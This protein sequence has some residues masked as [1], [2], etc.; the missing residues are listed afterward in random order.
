MIVAGDPNG[1]P[2]DSPTN[3]VIPNSDI[4]SPFA[5]VG[6][7]QIQSGGSTFICTATPISARHVIS[8][9]HCLDLDANGSVD[10]PP[11]NVDFILNYGSDISHII[12]A[13]ALFVHPDWTGFA[14]P[15]VNDDVAVIELSTPLPDGVPIYGLNSDPFVS[16]ETLSMVG[17]GQSG[18]GVNGY[19]VGASFS[20][21]RGGGNDADSFELDDEGSGS[22]EVFYADFD[23]PTSSTNFLGGLTLGNDIETTLG[24]GDSGGPSFIDDG[25]GGI[26]IF[27]IN[28]FSFQ[29]TATLAPRFGS[30]AGGT[31]VSAYLDFIDPIIGP[32]D[33]GVTVAESG[34]LT[35]VIEGGA[36]DTYTFVL[37][38]APTANVAITS[39]SDTE[40]ST[41][42]AGVVFT[43]TNWNVAQ[44]VTV[45]AVDD[46]DVEGNHT[47]TITH[48][49]ASAD[50]AYNG[51]S[52]DGI[53]ANITD[54]DDPPI[55]PLAV[56]VGVANNV[57]DA[58]TTVS[59]NH[60]FSSMIVVAS[61]NYGGSDSPLVTRVR[62][63]SGNSFQV[64]VQRPNNGAVA[65]TGFD[66]HYLAVEAG[67]YTVASNGVKMEAVSFTS[68]VTDENNSWQGESKSYSNSYTN[69]VVIGQVMTQ[70]D[71]DWSVFWA[72]GN[73]RTAP[74]NSSNLT[75]GKHVA[76]DPTTARANETIGYVVLEA[77][78]G[79]I[80]STVNYVAALGADTIRGITDAPP[81]TYAL[82]GLSSVT[83]AVVSSAAMD[84][85]NGGWPLLYGTNP[86][87]PTALRLAIDEDQLRDPE[88]N[89][90][91]EQ[92]AY[93]VF[94][95]IGE[96]PSVTIQP[97]DGSTDVGEDGTTDTYTVVLEAQPTADVTINVSGDGQVAGA[98]VSL[99]FTALNWDTTQSVTVSAVDDDVAEGNH[100]GSIGHTATSADTA[101]DGIS[102]AGVQANI[103]DNDSAG[104]TISP[105]GGSTDVSEDGVT[106]GYTVVLTS[107]PTANVTITVGGDSQV[108][109][110]PTPLT[111]TPTNWGTAQTVTVSAADD[112]VDE[113]DHTGILTH[114]AVS[115]DGS[116]NGIS[117]S[118]VQ[119]NITDN[120]T[121]GVVITITGGSTDV[122]E[123]GATDNYSVVLSSQ[124][125]ANVTVTVN[126]DGQVTGTPTPLTFTAGNWDTVQ[127]VTVSAVDDGV[128]EGNH[129]GVL[130]HSATSSDGNYNGNSIA[131]V[132]ANITDNDSAG[133]VV[134]ESSGSTD[135]AEGGTSD[136]YTLVLTSQPTAT[137]TVTINSDS[138]VTGAPAPLTFTSANWDTAQTVTVT[139]V[140]DGVVEGNHAGTISHTAVSGDTD[141]NGISI[142]DVTANVTDNDSVGVEIVESGG[143]T[144]VAEGGASDTYA[145]VLTSQ[146]SGNVTITVG[147]DGQV[148]GSPGLLTFTSGNWNSAQTVAVTAVDD[149][150]VEGNHTGVLNHTAS[151]GDGSYDGISITDVTAN[152]TDNDSAGPNL[153]VGV[154]QNVNDAWTTVVLTST[155]SSMVVVASVNYD[156]SDAPMVTRVRNASG[157]SFEL[158][159]QRPNGG[160]VS[161]SGF[162]VHYFVVEE[163]VYTAANDG[164]TME[165]VRYTSTLT[166]RRG[167]WQGQSRSYSNSYNS[168]VVVG[169]VMSGNDQ[170]WSVFW[171]RGANRSSVPS[172]STLFVGKHVGEDSDRTRANETVGYVVLETGGGSVGSLSY[173]V[174]VGS[175]TIR[176][177]GNS[178]P[179]SYTLSGIENPQAVVV[180]SAAM[181]GNDG[182][183]P[184][185]YGSTP[186][187]S[188]N[189]NLSIDE[190]QIR[191]GETR[192]TT[193]QVAYIV[194]GTSSAQRGTATIPE[195]ESGFDIKTIETP[196]GAASS[197]TTLQRDF[198]ST[199]LVSAG[200]ADVGRNDAFLGGQHANESRE[201]RPVVA[202]RPDFMRLPTGRIKTSG[203]RPA[204]ADDT[205]LSDLLFEALV[206]HKLVDD[207]LLELLARARHN[208]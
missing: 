29:F 143:S 62:S 17:H 158:R 138:Q 84:G 93:V 154:V 146:P 15:S 179:Y 165:A 39:N 141:F 185:L 180:S 135:V 73:S 192:H 144:D 68:T 104:V 16:I 204:Q 74:P 205:V 59:L 56:R 6:S 107:Q 170:D 173:S 106:D 167:S 4:S 75:I 202:A 87:T 208:R 81:Y 127:V 77:G 79:T 161:V 46:S 66:V 5:G 114:S 164:I 152:I 65:A 148:T 86:L 8:A 198:K 23:G 94:E 125:T 149:G 57:T 129:T 22:R 24:G 103:A 110:S 186:L 20:V 172:A 182:G 176:G 92:V 189:L 67:V 89:H 31:I 44:T 105:S 100:T 37:N 41:T 9:A 58:W 97:T 153:D 177:T 113:G 38:A 187:T 155:Y 95:Q 133:V 206:D 78:N 98:P 121:S 115:G 88:R 43:P 26:K 156:G 200:L 72:T 134:V 171:A 188:S 166:D 191:D 82:S 184:V 147:E 174:A 181:D 69:P 116:Y 124:P 48:S 1:S 99:T 52:I 162:P 178:P 142:T 12:E 194:F 112:D 130:S 83:A 63:A 126:G 49:A 25:N 175:D 11:S 136:T 122:S 123:A 32:G 128:I 132:T 145:I 183:W 111:F 28:T 102:V 7:L 131:G 19:T 159:V 71:T 47:G 42:P 139:A 45:T 207:A 91:T 50:A 140:D 120:D 54:N 108:G 119:A 109:G 195:G 151:S 18:D 33:A 13:S 117:I 61:I 201:R 70:N 193:E 27:G 36:T 64:R 14:S 21:K 196:V 85:G 96:T 76:E 197:L 60:S 80:E 157:S 150:D 163:G 199:W 2:S 3:R 51:I 190:D 118:S 90:T 34:G 168:P 35:N 30:G 53:T 55:A 101:Y 137:V 40:V 10:I 203:S 169:Q 160:A